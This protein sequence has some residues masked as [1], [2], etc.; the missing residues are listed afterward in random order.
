LG[1]K[2]S[3]IRYWETEFK[4]LNP[5]KNRAGNRIYKEDDIDTIRLIHHYVHEKHL[6]IHDANDLIQDLKKEQLYTRKVKELSLIPVKILNESPDDDDL[7][8]PL[9]DED[10][11]DKDFIEPLDDE[12]F[13]DEDEKENLD[14]E[15]VTRPKKDFKPEP[16][17]EYVLDEEE[18]TTEEEDDDPGED[19]EDELE[20][21]PT[22]MEFEIVSPTK[23]TFIY[24]LE[25]EAEENEEI[26]ETPIIKKEIPLPLPNKET[27]QKSDPELRKLLKKISSNI[28]DI[29]DILQE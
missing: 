26:P 5:Q 22:D 6:S 4:D 19:V 28:N 14:F 9:P 17:M 13:E 15:I 20:K 7:I 29:I 24:P 1:I 10:D 8:E 27:A 16:F 12:G 2:P 21:Y 25:E 23:E 3:V 11:F 18:E